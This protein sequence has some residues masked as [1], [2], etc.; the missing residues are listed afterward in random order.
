MNNRLAFVVE[1]DASVAE[2]FAEVLRQSGFVV[3][4]LRSGKAARERLAQ[5]VPIMVVLDLNLPVVSG[6]ILLAEIRADPRLADTRVIVATGEPHRA[7]AL[8]VQPD[9]LLV[10]PVSVSQISAFANRLLFGTGTLSGPDEP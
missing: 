6:D 10:K 8:E 4:V 7:R 5:A 9:L 2:A 3:E 1:D